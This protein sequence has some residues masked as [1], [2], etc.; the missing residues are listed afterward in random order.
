VRLEKY[1]NEALGPSDADSKFNYNSA[2]K[3][4]YRP[5]KWGQKISEYKMILSFIQTDEYLK[6]ISE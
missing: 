3:I 4:V 2:P 6:F 5:K 1:F